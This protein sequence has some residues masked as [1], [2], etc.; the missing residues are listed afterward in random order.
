MLKTNAVDFNY[1]EVNNA[2]GDITV[3]REVIGEKAV[4]LCLILAI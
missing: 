3:L 2:Y 4:K 1:L